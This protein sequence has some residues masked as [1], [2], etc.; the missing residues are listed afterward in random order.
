MHWNV[1][2]EA[3]L[4]GRRPVK[5][6]YQSHSKARGQERTITRKALVE[7]PWKTE[8]VELTIAKKILQGAG[9]PAHMVEEEDEEP[10]QDDPLEALLAS[11]D[12]D[13]EE[14]ADDE[15]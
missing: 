6:T 7:H 4:A 11:E 1:I 12:E 9:R 2:Q 8:L 3:E 5:A 10:V 14:P 15:M 13:E